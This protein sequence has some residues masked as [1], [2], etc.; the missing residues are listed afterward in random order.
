MVSILLNGQQGTDLLK[1]VCSCNHYKPQTGQTD[2]SLQA[3]VIAVLASLCHAKM[4]QYPPN[5]Q[6]TGE[7]M[8]QFSDSEIFDRQQFSQFTEGDPE[9]ERDIIQLF[10][11]HTAKDI[12]NLKRYFDQRNYQKWN[13]IAHKLHGMAINLG[14]PRLQHICDKGQELS[15][16]DSDAIHDIH[17]KILIEY[18]RLYD[19][20]QKQYLP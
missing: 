5:Y 16:T 11:E 18:Q 17:A 12:N 19:L 3:C 9:V 2:K 10:F 13:D 1:I 4:R 15:V 20:L 7:S 8:S 14:A 6:P